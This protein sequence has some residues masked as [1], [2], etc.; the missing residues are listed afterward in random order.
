MA[1]DSELLL[2][3]RE[4]RGILQQRLDGIESGQDKGFRDLR[5]RTWIAWAALAL[6]VIVPAI[7]EAY[8]R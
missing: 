4:L 6:F 8:S 5:A 1:T 7:V 2:E 3:V